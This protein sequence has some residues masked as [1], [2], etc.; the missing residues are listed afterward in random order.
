M[1][2]TYVIWI[3]TADGR[4]IEAFTWTRDKDSGIAR[5]KREGKEFGYSDFT[6]T[7]IPVEQEEV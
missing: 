6:V 2:P 3:E 5:A 4:K 1:K 7:A